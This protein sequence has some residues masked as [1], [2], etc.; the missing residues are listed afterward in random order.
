MLIDCAALKS[1]CIA[2]G[3]I[4]ILRLVQRLACLL[5]SLASPVGSFARIVQFDNG[6]V[7]FL[8]PSSKQGRKL[9]N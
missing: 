5:L 8:P 7:C 9:R 1:E 2:S 4:A 6:I 3:G